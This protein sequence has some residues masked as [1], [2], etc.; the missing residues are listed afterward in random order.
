M[1][2]ALIRHGEAENSSPDEERQLSASGKR[3]IMGLGAFLAGTGW[4]FHSIF[5]SPLVRTRQ[6]AH[7]LSE[8]L[9]CAPDPWTILR[10]GASPEGVASE[11][12]EVEPNRAVALVFHM[13]DVARIAAYLLGSRDTSFYIPPGTVL[14]M[15]LPARPSPG[16]A[17]LL[18][19][20]QPEFYTE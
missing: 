19:S 12:S 16:S 3:D 8:R 20:L 4:Q 7:I 5:H 17:L 6:T 11:L 18:F 13:P 2:V 14:G 9:N 10:P 15:N 1:K